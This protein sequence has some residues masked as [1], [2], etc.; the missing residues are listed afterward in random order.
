ML[1]AIKSEMG[2]FECSGVCGCILQLV[3]VLLFAVNPPDIGRSGERFLRR[4]DTL[5]KDL[6]ASQ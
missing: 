3:Y 5:Y 2:V 4:R 1:A 6:F